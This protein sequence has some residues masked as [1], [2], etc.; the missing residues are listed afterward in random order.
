MVTIHFDLTNHLSLQQY[1]DFIETCAGVCTKWVEQKCDK[2]LKEI[3]DEH[4]NYQQRTDRWWKRATRWVTFNVGIDE[5]NSSDFMKL[6][7][8]YLEE[9]GETLKRIAYQKEV[10]LSFAERYNSV[11]VE[12]DAYKLFNV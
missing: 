4:K 5:C 11:S 1:K 8:L 12:A 6:R 7:S 2:E 3:R 10:Y 9:R